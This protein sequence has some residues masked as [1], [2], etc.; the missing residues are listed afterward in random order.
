MLWSLAAWSSP[1]FFEAKKKKFFHLAAAGSAED[2]KCSEKR[3]FL[4]NSWSRLKKVVLNISQESLI[5]QSNFR[6]DVIG[7]CAKQQERRGKLRSR[8]KVIR[9]CISPAL[10]F[11]RIGSSAE[12]EV[13]VIF[14]FIT[15]SVICT[16]NL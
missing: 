6:H 15:Y 14:L 13:V 2:I 16:N 11:V 7:A 10:L 8:I 3:P 5:L 9:A 12:C 4:Q 1:R